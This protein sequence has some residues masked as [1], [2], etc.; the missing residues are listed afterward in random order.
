MPAGSTVSL[1]NSTT[2][3]PS[4]TPDFN[5]FYVLSLTVNDGQSSSPLDTVVVQARL[6]SFVNTTLQAYL[7]ASNTQTAV[8]SGVNDNF[9]FK[10]ALSGDTLAVVATGEDSCATGINGDQTNNDCQSAGAV[11]VFTRTQGSWTQ[12]AYLKASNTQTIDFFGESLALDGDTLAVSAHSEDSCATGINGEEANNGCSES[13]A[14]YVFTRTQGTWTQQAYLKASNTDSAD[15]FGTG[16]ALTGNTLAVGADSEAS[17]ATGIN[18][19]QTNND[20][21]QAGAVYVFTRT[22]GIWKQE[23]YVKASNTKAFD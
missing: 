9:G 10:V 12:Q 14:V 22:N 19:D 17:C 1:A 2:V 23:A 20:C 4:F 7:K 11:Y 6:P 21:F 5:G 8:N 16:L 13:G 18:G 15:F 3:S